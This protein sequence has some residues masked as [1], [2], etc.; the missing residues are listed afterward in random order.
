MM[1]GRLSSWCYRHRFVVLVAWI[2]VVGAGFVASG[3]V[4]AALNQQTSTSFESTAAG[5][6]VSDAS[7]DA[8]TVVAV[9][10]RVDPT[11]AATRSV[12]T[13]VA[14][15]VRGLGGVR[16]VDDPY[17]GG[18]GLVASDHRAVLVI[19]HIART[20]PASDRTALEDAVSARLRTMTG[21][22]PGSQV[23]LGG[24]LLLNRQISA[25]VQGDLNRAEYISLPVVL[26]FMVLVFGGFVAAGLP[27]LGAITSV[28]A[29][30]L[31]LWGLST[32]ASL[33]ND[34]VTV[35]TVL[36]LGLSIDYGLLLLSRYREELARGRSR[37][38]AV[39]VAGATAGRTIAFSALTVAAALGG[40]LVVDVPFLQA[41]GAAGLSVALVTLFSALTLVPALIR[42]AAKRIKPAMHT[43][44]STG[45]FFARLAGGVQRH[46]VLVLAVAG[47]ALVAAMLP[48][49]GV[50]I[51]NP[52]LQGI[53]T[54]IESRQVVDVLSTRFGQSSTPA[55]T[56]VVRADPAVLDAWAA[57]HTHDAGVARVDPAQAAGDGLST[58][59]FT[60]RGDPNGA[61]ARAL[62]G[63]L[64]ADRPQDVRSWV[65]G[66]AAVS[67]DQLDQLDRDLPLA[68]GVSVLAMLILL[69]LMTGSAVIPLKALLMNLIS[70]GATFGIMVAVFQHGLFAGP[71][72]LL[73]VDGLSPF[74]LVVVFAFAFGL[75]MDYEVFLLSRI[76]EQHDAG[77]PDDVAV[78]EGLRRSGRIITSAAACMIIVFSCFVLGHVSDVQQIGL[79]LVL[80]VLIDA[81]I[82]RCLLV[83]A[84]MTLLGRRNWWAPGWLTAVHRRLGLHESTPVPALPGTEPGKEPGEEH[85]RERALTG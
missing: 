25:T 12:V 62:V 50:K 53:P 22:L 21:A 4:F 1:F 55:A 66:G 10:D 84:T 83:P 30:M 32:F 26:L 6:L 46:P 33:D 20:V 7:P 65:T 77:A 2:A 63:T 35:T 31:G 57:R 45:G 39:A 42:V 15:D 47:L 58:V 11:S 8:G 43:E 23:R 73:T 67:K 48:V 82:V 28:G 54:S 64:R 79:G 52:G 74:N 13:G 36:G 61:Q 76:K 27:V 37:P 16:A 44:G 68:I 29:A 51:T 18:R 41:I 9:L 14:G 49:L 38:D 81:T 69:F 5:Q 80:A 56:V 24:S 60:V 17:D 72:H 85:D 75:S 34:T 19:T 78:R 59:D 71:L 40:L 70:T 3:P